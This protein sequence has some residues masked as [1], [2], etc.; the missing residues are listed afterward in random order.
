MS[1]AN[2]DVFADWKQ[3]RFIVAP[4][5]LIDFEGAH[6]I[7]LTDY[8]Y[9]SEHYSQLEAWCHDHDCE[10]RG[11]TVAIPNDVVLTAFYLR[12]A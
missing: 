4:T 5:K 1:T 3:N 8:T 2:N 6:L 9:W 10:S 7:I 12:W 11:M